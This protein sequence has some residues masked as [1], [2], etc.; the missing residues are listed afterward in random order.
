MQAIRHR[1]GLRS[2]VLAIAG[3]LVLSMGTADVASAATCKLPKSERQDTTGKK[4]PSYTRKMRATRTS[5]KNARRIAKSFYSCRK[6]NGG[7][8]GRC[9]KKVRKYKCSEK[10]FNVIAIQYD[11]RVTCKRGKASVTFE[12]TQFT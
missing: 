3:G 10:R 12:Y 4:G 11:S 5:C 1:G 9:R 7:A 8:D 6:K 2:T